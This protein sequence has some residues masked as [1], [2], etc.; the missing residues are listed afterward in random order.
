MPT[1]PL[2]PLE[3][4]RLILRRFRE[5]DLE[6]L[7]A[8]LSRPEVVKFEPYQPMN[9]EES[10]AELAARIES[11]EMIAVEEK[12]TGR[13]LGNLYLGKREFASMELGYV[14]HDTY[15]HQGFAREGCEALI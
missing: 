2:L 1:N 14:F 11:V 10:K 5:D 9:L 3:T 6:D 4:Q 8:Y 15:W 12:A 13:L 7:Y